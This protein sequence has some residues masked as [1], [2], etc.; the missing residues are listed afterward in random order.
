MA[1]IRKRKDTG[2][3]EIAFK[4]EEGRRKRLCNF[5]TKPEAT[6]AL[7]KITEEIENGT[8]GRIN[9]EL[10]FK[11]ATEKYIE[12]YAKIHCKEST[13]SG[14]QG[15]LNN[16]LLP[17]FGHRKMI[18]IT[19][20]QIEEFIGT[21]K[22]KGLSSETINHI[23]FLFGAVFEKMID[24]GIIKI[25]P[26]KRVKKLGAYTKKADF[27]TAEEIG[28]C[29]TVAKNNYP[30]YYVLL[31]TA[32]YTGMRQGELFALTWNDISFE[33]RIIKVNKS[34]SHGQL[35][36][37]KTDSS[38]RNVRI[39]NS[40]MD[41]LKQWREEYQRNENNLVFPNANGGYLDSRN[42]LQRFFHKCLED[43]GL[44]KIRWHDL[45]HTHISL[46][47]NQNVAPQVIQKQAGHS[48]IK[49]TMDV[50]GHLMPSVYNSSID[51]IDNVLVIQEKPRLRLV[52]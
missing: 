13:V 15:Y 41:V 1:S 17:V 6:L 40:L 24:D 21:L 35:S 19:K 4:D 52:K 43:A 27:L 10:T 44:K 33:D 38:V 3:W 31:Y 12:Q 20:P 2:K 47:I 48:T 30:Q 5:K 9:K 45:R 36:T 22:E 32:I 8:Y 29:L 49:T 34:Y 37:T 25:N 23:I 11:E 16:H 42:I 46:L 14:Y 7:A 18:N 51:A 39:C 28:K 26:V 50:Y